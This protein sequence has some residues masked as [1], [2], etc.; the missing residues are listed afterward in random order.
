MLTEKKP[1]RL[2]VLVRSDLETTYR[3]VQGIHAVE[4]LYN[5]SIHP[6]KHSGTIVQLAVRNE[7]EMKYWAEKLIMRGK[8]FSHFNEPDL[9]GQMT[10]IACIDTGKIFS[11]L[12]LSK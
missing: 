7:Q 11:K 5:Q 2:Y 12:P 4:T 1:L 8:T 6:P 9:N 3:G 10:A